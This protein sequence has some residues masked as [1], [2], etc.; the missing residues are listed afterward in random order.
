[1][2]A[3][4]VRRWCLHLLTGFSSMSFWAFWEAIA[5]ASGEGDEKKLRKKFNI[6]NGEERVDGRRR[7]VWLLN[8]AAAGTATLKA[9]GTVAAAVGDKAGRRRGGAAR[10]ALVVCI[11]L[12]QLLGLALVMQLGDAIGWA[13]WWR[14][15]ARKRA[16]DLKSILRVNWSERV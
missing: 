10:R 16:F 13:Y 11:C 2:T 3:S 6:G 12:Q 5:T 8:L 7:K 14:L 1:M 15:A 9:A 4:I